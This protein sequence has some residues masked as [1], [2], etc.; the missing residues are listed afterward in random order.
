M[1]SSMNSHSSYFV[2]LVPLWLII[3]RE[4]WGLESES[5]SV[6]AQ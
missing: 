5:D 2:F 6:L 1:S 3:M 4:G